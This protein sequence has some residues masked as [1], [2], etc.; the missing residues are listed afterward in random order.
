MSRITLKHITCDTFL[1]NWLHAFELPRRFTEFAVR[2]HT[3]AAAVRQP[4]PIAGQDNAP[5][6]FIAAEVAHENAQRPTTFLS[7]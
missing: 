6:R 3:V 7:R 1:G 2:H 5:T 4:E